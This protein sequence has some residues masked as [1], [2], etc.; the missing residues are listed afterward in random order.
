MKNIHW[1]GAV[2]V[3]ALGYY[4]GMKYPNLLSKVTG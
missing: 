2:L 4:I 3:L 1:L